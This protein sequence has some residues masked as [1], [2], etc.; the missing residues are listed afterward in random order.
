[1]LNLERPLGDKSGG[2]ILGQVSCLDNF[3]GA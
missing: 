1:M 2:D 3:L